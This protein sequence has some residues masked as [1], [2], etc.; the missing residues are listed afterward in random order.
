MGEY[1][2][3]PDSR[4]RGP[5]NNVGFLQDSRTFG[6]TIRQRVMGFD[7]RHDAPIAELSQ[8]VLP[9]YH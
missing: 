7:N 2:K 1:E 4:R 6:I 3:I 9:W 8:K 5:K